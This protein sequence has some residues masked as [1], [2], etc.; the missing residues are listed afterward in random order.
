MDPSLS[1]PPVHTISR[2]T[3]SSRPCE[4]SSVRAH[5]YIQVQ[6]LHLEYRTLTPPLPQGPTAA[7]GSSTHSHGVRNPGGGGACPSFPASSPTPTCSQK[8][9]HTP[10]VSQVPLLISSPPSRPR[11]RPPRTLRGPPPPDCPIVTA[12]DG[13][14]HHSRAA[15]SSERKPSVQAWPQSP[16][17]PCSGPPLQPV[18]SPAT[19][20]TF[21]PFTSLSTGCLTHPLQLTALHPPSPPSRAQLTCC[22]GLCPSVPIVPRAPG[23]QFLSPFSRISST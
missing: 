8:A 23:G 9:N 6:E 4:P 19:A 14:A 3:L 10:S 13:S 21:P 20:S 12:P 7:R 11:L 22:T 18:P 16:R 5:L 2:A 17:S 1:S 15:V